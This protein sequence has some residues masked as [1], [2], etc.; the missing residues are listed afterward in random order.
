MAVKKGRGQAAVTSRKGSPGGKSLNA[1]RMT[2]LLGECLRGG[3]RPVCVRTGGAARGYYLDDPPTPVCPSVTVFLCNR[4]PWS[5]RVCAEIERE[6]PGR[7]CMGVKVWSAD[8]GAS[9]EAP[10]IR[11]ELLSFLGLEAER[12]CG[13]RLVYDG[14]W[15]WSRY[16]TWDGQG[17]VDPA[18]GGIPCFREPNEAL[19]R[20]EDLD[21]LEMFLGK[22]A[23]LWQELLDRGQ[24]V[25]R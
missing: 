11:E 19:E 14:W 24:Q 21:V 10:G 12:S 3:G 1:V 18:D 15:L 9:L 8:K 13:I 2:E 17:T 22:A 6:R 7:I 16:L 25:R 5:L 23:D 20:L 4:E